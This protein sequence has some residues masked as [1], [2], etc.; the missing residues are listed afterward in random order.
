MT[1]VICG[2]YAADS[3]EPVC[4]EDTLAV[5]GAGGGGSGGVNVYRLLV[6]TYISPGV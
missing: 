6:M 1:S 4:R 3:T 5:V 2:V